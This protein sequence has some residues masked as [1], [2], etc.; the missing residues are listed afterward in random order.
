MNKLQ[1]LFKLQH[2]HH[3]RYTQGTISNYCLHNNEK[4]NH[5]YVMAF[6]LNIILETVV[7]K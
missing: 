5:L 2:S 6:D 7:V 4:E 1:L 3:E